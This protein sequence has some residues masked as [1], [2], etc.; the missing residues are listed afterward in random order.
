[1][2]ERTVVIE[3]VF[4]PKFP[5]QGSYKVITDGKNPHIGLAAQNL[6]VLGY[7][8][9]G[10]G[11]PGWHSVGSVVCHPS[12]GKQRVLA[13]AHVIRGGDWQSAREGPAPMQ[14]YLIPIAE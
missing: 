10:P 11:I 6:C 1:M 12:N 8:N 2:S 14:K 7:D 9:M 3:N 5:V 4:P 13:P